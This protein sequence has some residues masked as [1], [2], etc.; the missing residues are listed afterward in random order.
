MSDLLKELSGHIE[1][2][3]ANRKYAN[4]SVLARISGV[5]YPTLRRIV[6]GEMTPS[7]QTVMQLAPVLLEQTPAQQFVA[8]HF[9]EVG[10]LYRFGDGG[11]YQV[12]EGHMAYT[13]FTKEEFII[14]GLA[15]REG[16]IRRSRLVEKLGESAYSAIDR[17]LGHELI[18]ETDG[19]LKT[20]DENPY[21]PG[22]DG[23]LHLIRLAIDCFDKDKE[24]DY[25]TYYMMFTSGLNDD[26]I[27]AA[28]RVMN[29]AEKK[30]LTVFNEPSFKG[31]KVLYYTLLS[32]YLE[33]KEE[34]S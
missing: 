4:L 1:L 10:K 2:W 33:S 11:G 14:F 21:V 27:K 24:L 3:L 29:E 22:L 12:A 26:G 28:H 9:P 19:V 31:Q 17:L 30:L 8:K 20:R 5:S 34:F 16:G 23:V 6:Q 32:S 18:V 7:L 15:T 13:S 25:G